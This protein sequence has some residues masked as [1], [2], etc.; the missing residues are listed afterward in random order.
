M[1]KF[2]VKNWKRFQH[3]KNRTPPWIKFHNSTLDDYAFRA[4]PDYAKAHLMCIWLLASRYQNDIPADPDFIREMIGA[5]SAV[6]LNILEQAGF[7]EIDQRCS[8]PLAARKQRAT[9]EAEGEIEAEIEAEED[10]GSYEP[11]SSGDDA[12]KNSTRENAETMMAMWNELASRYPCLP[13]VERLTDQ[14]QE[15]LDKIE[16]SGH[17]LGNNDRGWVANFDFLLQPSSLTKLLE[18]NYDD[19]RVITHS[20]LTLAAL[21][22]RADRED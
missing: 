7:I 16:I 19:R 22:E 18:G 21:E 14:R 11:L 13:V 4:L 6:D 3:Y 1:Q 8:K 2:R 10:R 12:P 20:P 15:A 17:C 9:P 5:K